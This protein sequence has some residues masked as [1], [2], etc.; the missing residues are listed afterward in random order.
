MKGRVD[1]QM[2]ITEYLAGQKGR[3]MKERVDGQVD[4]QKDGQKRV[5]YLNKS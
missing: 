4:E 5:E 1:G 3:Q 2:I